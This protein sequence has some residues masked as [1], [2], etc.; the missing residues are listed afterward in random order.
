GLDVSTVIYKEIFGQD[1]DPAP[2]SWSTVDDK[3]CADIWLDGSSSKDGGSNASGA[4]TSSPVAVAP[5]ATASSPATGDSTTNA[6][7]SG[8]EDGYSPAAVFGGS[9][10]KS[11]SYLPS[12]P[13]VPTA[14]STITAPTAGNGASQV[15][16]KQATME[17]INNP[18][19]GAGATWS[20]SWTYGP[21]LVAILPLALPW[22]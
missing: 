20:R 19:N 7:A 22:I 1:T 16:P 4:P 21:W 3:H 9:N 6:D 11:P 2:A 18:A 10:S 14:Q 15:F 13:S 12:P 5:M 17:D 8:G